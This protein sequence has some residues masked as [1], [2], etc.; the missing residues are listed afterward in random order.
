MLFTF[1]AIC[2]L[3]GLANN[4]GVDTLAMLAMFDVLNIALGIF[5]YHKQL[6]RS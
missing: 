5:I 4:P 1:G 2:I 6:K 3:A